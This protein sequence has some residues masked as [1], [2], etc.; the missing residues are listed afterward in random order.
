MLKNRRGRIVNIASVVGRAGTGSPGE[1]RRV[2]ARR[3]RLGS[4]NRWR[5]QAASRRNYSKRQTGLLETGMAVVLSEEALKAM[6]GGRFRLDGVA[7]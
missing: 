1:P 7:R 6:H 4:Q 2:E 5:A 3:D